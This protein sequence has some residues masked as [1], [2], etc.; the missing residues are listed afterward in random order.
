MNTTTIPEAA[1]HYSSLQI[2]RREIRLQDNFREYHELMR[3]YWR[4]KGDINRTQ[5]H[6]RH[7]AEA[8]QKVRQMGLRVRELEQGAAV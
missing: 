7:A 1:Q 2:L 5:A 3:D 8:A 4:K 6:E